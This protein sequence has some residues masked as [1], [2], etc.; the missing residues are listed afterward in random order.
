MFSGRVLARP[1]GHPV[2]R[3]PRGNANTSPRRLPSPVSRMTC[4]AF[5]NLGATKSSI[6]RTE[7]AQSVINHAA[8]LPVAV[9]VVGIYPPLR[10]KGAKC[11]ICFTGG[12]TLSIF[13]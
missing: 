9:H 11:V 12:V 13:I 6:V 5:R 7:D 2:M 8:P 4:A 10:L 1:F 3:Q